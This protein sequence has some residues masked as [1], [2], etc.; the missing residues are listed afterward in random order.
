M[1]GKSDDSRK[2]PSGHGSNSKRLATAPNPDTGET[3]TIPT[4]RA[5]AVAWYVA[6]ADGG[7]TDRPVVM[8]DEDAGQIIEGTVIHVE[9][10]RQGQGMGA[11]TA[12]R[13]AEVR[14]IL[15]RFS[16][17]YGQLVRKVLLIPVASA[18]SIGDISVSDFDDLELN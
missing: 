9:E 8:I 16:G 15:R 10:M 4:A 11:M 13:V 18:D 5:V 2:R 3:L 6:N 7:W 12:Y 1:A 14:Q 17:K